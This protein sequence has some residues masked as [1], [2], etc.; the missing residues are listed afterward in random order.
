M[1]SASK[2][3]VEKVYQVLVNNPAMNLTISGYTDSAGREDSNL[4][5]S[6]KRAKAVNDYLVEKG[7]EAS[8]LTHD[9]YGEADPIA[10]NS[11]SAGRAKNR[12]VEFTPT[13]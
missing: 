5:L 9:G 3:L 1:T 6:K 4:A 12:R 2:P 7:I 10:D 8:R 13:Y 11:T